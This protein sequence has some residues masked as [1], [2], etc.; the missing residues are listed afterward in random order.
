M[1]VPHFISLSFGIKRNISE[2]I[3]LIESSEFACSSNL[4]FRAEGGGWVGLVVGEGAG[5]TARWIH[6][7]SSNNIS[8]Y[9]PCEIVMEEELGKSIPALT[10]PLGSSHNTNAGTTQLVCS[11]IALLTC[12]PAAGWRGG[13]G[14][15]LSHAYLH[16]R[17]VFLIDTDRRARWRP[18]LRQSPTI[19][20][21]SLPCSFPHSYQIPPAYSAHTL[22]GTYW[23]NISCLPVFFMSLHHF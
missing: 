17:L 20:S 22:P 6:P 9:V 11:Q 4:H 16:R 23:E 13:R 3:S 15:C 10:P 12:A 7:C 8:I 1:G 2:I 14:L 19:V 18:L 5:S 21:P